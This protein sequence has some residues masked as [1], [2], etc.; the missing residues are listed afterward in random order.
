MS[1]EWSVPRSTWSAPN[2]ST[3]KRKTCRVIHHG[4]EVEPAEHLVYGTGELLTRLG[5][6][7]VTVAPSADERRSYAAA[8]REDEFQFGKRSRTPPK[9]RLAT[10]TAVSTGLPIRFCK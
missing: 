4:V 9:I 8:M 3:K 5:P 7:G 1:P 6:M 10:A 2:V